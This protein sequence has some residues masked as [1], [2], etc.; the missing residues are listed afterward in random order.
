LFCI[1]AMF[2]GV[3]IQPGDELSTKPND[4][5]TKTNDGTTKTN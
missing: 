4:G 5:T 2:S 3:G 1:A